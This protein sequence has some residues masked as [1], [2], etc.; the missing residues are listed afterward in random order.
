MGNR[1]AKPRIG[2]RIMKHK[3][4]APGSKLLTFLI[5]SFCTAIV[6]FAAVLKIT[7]DLA[8]YLFHIKLNSFITSTGLL[9]IILLILFIGRYALLDKLMK[10]MIVVLAS[11]CIK[12]QVT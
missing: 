2:E 3:L 8:A 11:K 5:L 1:L 12:R 10:G 4:L 6:N 9:L 7:S